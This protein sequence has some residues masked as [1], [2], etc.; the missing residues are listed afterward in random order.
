MS[1]R[2]ISAWRAG[3]LQELNESFKYLLAAVHNKYIV[4]GSL[5][6]R[7][8]IKSAFPLVV[9]RLFIINHSPR[10]VEDFYL[11]MGIA[12]Y[13]LNGPRIIFPVSVRADHIIAYK[14]VI[15]QNLYL[16]IL[17]GAASFGIGTGDTVRGVLLWPYCQRSLVPSALNAGAVRPL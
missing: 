5:V 10:T 14:L 4:I 17:F 11:V 12:L 7:P 15:R 2:M 13:V 6:Q 1:S 8:A 3:Y 9:I 16:E